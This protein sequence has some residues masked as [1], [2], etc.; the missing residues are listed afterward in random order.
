MLHATSTLHAIR[1]LHATRTVHATLALHATCKLDTACNI[2]YSTIMT[3]SN[4]N[5]TSIADYGCSTSENV[6]TFDQTI[7]NILINIGSTALSYSVVVYYLHPTTICNC[8]IF[9]NL[10]INTNI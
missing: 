8:S 5:S 7:K 2:M 6:I 9:F 10:K 1:I 3:C 4:C